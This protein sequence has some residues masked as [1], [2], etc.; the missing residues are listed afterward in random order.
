MPS[1]L[2]IP[3]LTG[4]LA[5]FSPMGPIAV[6]EKIHEAVNQLGTT[7]EGTGDTVTPVHFGKNF[8][9]L[10]LL[11]PDPKIENCT[12]PATAIALDR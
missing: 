1:I 12:E 4:P 3:G 10:A 2:L 8:Q 7:L 6:S 5:T 11:N 9:F